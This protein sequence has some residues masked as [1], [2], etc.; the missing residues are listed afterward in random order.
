MD[1][2]LNES[3]GMGKDKEQGKDQDKGQGKVSHATETMEG[4][5]LMVHWKE[6]VAIV[7]AQVIEFSWEI[8]LERRIQ[9]IL[10]A[11]EIFWLRMRAK[12]RATTTMKQDIRLEGD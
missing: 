10:E 11:K 4:D 6:I 1:Q 2:G 5:N 3:Q 7:G 12:E 8:Y 9:M